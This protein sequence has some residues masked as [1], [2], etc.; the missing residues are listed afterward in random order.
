MGWL[1][2]NLK[3]SRQITKLIVDLAF[4]NHVDWDSIYV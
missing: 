2:L 4:E 3:K 1:V